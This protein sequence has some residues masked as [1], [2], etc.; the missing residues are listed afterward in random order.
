[1]WLVFTS[2]KKLSVYLD[3]LP[4]A[5]ENNPVALTVALCTI[6]CV[7]IFILTFILTRMFK[8]LIS[9]KFACAIRSHNLLYDNA[10]KQKGDK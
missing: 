2:Q 8:I 10:Q 4:Q 1:M 6:G 7:L 5:R 9:I 3:L